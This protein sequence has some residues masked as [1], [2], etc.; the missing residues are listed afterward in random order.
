VREALDL[1]EGDQ[2]V[3]R[4]QGDHAVLSRTSDVLDLA[5]TIAVPAA[6]RSTSG[7]RLSR[8]RD[9]RR[10]SNRLVRPDGD[11][12]AGVERLEPSSS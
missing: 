12:I 6:R 4:V 3:F 5:G 10:R 11:R 8:R 7:D 1:H 2:I 9:H